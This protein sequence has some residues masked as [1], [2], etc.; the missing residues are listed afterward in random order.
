MSKLFTIAFLFT[1][2]QLGAN[3]QVVPDIKLSTLE[4]A[5]FQTKQL[6]EIAGKPVVL[7]FWAT[8]CIPCLNELSAIN[9]NLDDWKKESKFEFYA[10]SEDDSR[11][12]KRVPALVNGKGWNFN[13]L[14]DKNQ[15]L[16]RELNLMNIP[17]TMVIKD[18]KII[19]RQ[20]GYV[21]GN[22]NELYKIIK[23]NQ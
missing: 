12:A 14:L 5:S 9:D 3:A 11:T 15:D 20:A 19:Y 2:A 22:E 18:G 6:N 8:W 17:Y 13:V 16:K 23:E 4:G 10:I 21:A 1:I 7:S